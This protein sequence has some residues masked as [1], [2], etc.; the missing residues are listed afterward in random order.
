MNS[1][2]IKYLENRDIALLGMGV[3]GSSTYCFLRKLF[4]DKTLAI[5]DSNVEIQNLPLF[6][7]DSNIDF[8]LGES[9]LNVLSNWELII[10]SPGISLKNIDINS[11]SEIASQT[12]LFLR[13]YGNQVIGITGTKGKSTT[14]SLICHLLN[15]LGKK[16]ELAGNIGI[17]SFDIIENLAPDSM[18][19]YELSSHQLERVSSS[20]HIA[21]LLNI[22]EEHLDYYNSFQD[23]QDAKFRIALFQNEADKFIYN[24]DSEIIKFRWADFDFKSNLMPFSLTKQFDKGCYVIDET[25]YFNGSVSEKLCTKSAIKS[26]LGEH[27]LLNI[28][29]AVNAV[30]CVINVSSQ[31]LLNAINSFK[32]LEHRMEFV[33]EFNNRLYYND[34]ISTI[35]EATIAACNSIQD[36]DTLILGGMDRGVDYRK[37]MSYISESTIRNFIFIGDAGERMYRIYLE[38]NK[39]T[40]K[41]LFCFNDFSEGIDTAKK[42]TAAKKVCLLSPAAASYGMFK[43]FE[44]RGKVF[45]QLVSSF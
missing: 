23:Y 26:L 40:E 45:K 12:E 39:K 38:L 37:L 18:V 7:N 44:E 5:A 22:F 25:I 24:F 32:P 1:D 16:A 9:Y 33:G 15:S 6:E 3:E 20:P 2:L 14:S 11:T 34:S 19:I 4:P 8:F 17:P 41:N 21:V 10:K 31:D 30:K 13:F 29:A 35:P 36:V 27:N 28:L 42:L 43:N